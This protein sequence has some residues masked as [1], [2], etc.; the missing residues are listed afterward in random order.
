MIAYRHQE[1][2]RESVG[3]PGVEVHLA[4]YLTHWQLSIDG[5]VSGPEREINWRIAEAAGWKIVEA[6][7]AH[8][9]FASQLVSDCFCSG[10]IEGLDKH[11]L[12]C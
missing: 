8:V 7:H 2:I 4:E 6:I 10:V 3:V 11:P 12:R 5:N 1:I 9:G